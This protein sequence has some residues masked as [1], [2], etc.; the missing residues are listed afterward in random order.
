MSIFIKF[1]LPSSFVTWTFVASILELILHNKLK[2]FI[3]AYLASQQDIRLQ[4]TKQVH[5]FT[6]NIKAGYQS[7]F[8]SMHDIEGYFTVCM[9]SGS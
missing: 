9:I 4:F 2:Y 7:L 5:D 1:E 8:Y 3:L 6:L